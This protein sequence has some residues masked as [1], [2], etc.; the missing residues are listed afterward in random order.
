MTD[1]DSNYL[2]ILYKSSNTEEAKQKRILGLKKANK[3][4][5]TTKLCKQCKKPFH[6]HG[7]PHSYWKAK[8]CCSE[9]CVKDA[10]RQALIKRMAT[11]EGKKLMNQKARNACDIW[12][13]KYKPVGG[14]AWIYA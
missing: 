13:Y 9:E 3:F 4:A 11:V 1:D 6:R 10:H 8:V 14:G 12:L 5:S 2:T 7:L